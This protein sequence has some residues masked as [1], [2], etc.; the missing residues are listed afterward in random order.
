MNSGLTGGVRAANQVNGFTAALDR[1]RHRGSIIDSGAME[2]FNSLDIQFPP[3]HA[4]SDEQRMTSNFC[5]IRK[6]NDLVGSIHANLR[7]GLRCEN[8][9]AETA[10]LH[11]CATREIGAGK[12]GW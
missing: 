4:G 1:L 11:H 6:L 7:S 10:C 9:D 5:S 3:L 2:S 8:F 12:P